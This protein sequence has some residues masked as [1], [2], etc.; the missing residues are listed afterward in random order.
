MGYSERLTIQA[1]EFSL[2][3]SVVGRNV[4]PQRYVIRLPHENLP[5]YVSALNVESVSSRLVVLFVEVRF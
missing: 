2:K 4:R 1:I 5:F 3:V